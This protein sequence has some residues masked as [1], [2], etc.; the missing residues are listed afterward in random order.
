MNASEALMQLVAAA[1]LDSAT[2][3]SEPW[4][5]RA[6]VIAVKLAETGVFKWPD[7]RE[8]LIEEIACSD[9]SQSADSVGTTEQYYD[10]FLRALER[11]IEEK[12]IAAK[13]RLI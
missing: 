5:A 9:A 11:M 3:F 8:R 10:H 2:V 12:G 6:F 13:H 4:Q 1:K 7:F